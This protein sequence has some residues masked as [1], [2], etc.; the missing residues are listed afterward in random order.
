L[1]D[2]FKKKTLNTGFPPFDFAFN[3]LK[4][5]LG[6]ACGAMTGLS[7][8]RIRRAEFAKIGTLHSL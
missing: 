3:K 1:C 7:N 6:Q 4:V 2:A 8:W 5:C